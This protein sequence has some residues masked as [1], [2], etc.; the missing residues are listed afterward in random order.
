M[1]T[2][3][4]NINKA[5]NSVKDLL[6]RGGSDDFRRTDPNSPDTYQT[7]YATTNENLSYL[8]NLDVANKDTLVVTGS[9]DHAL[10]LAYF[11]AKS[12]ETFDINQLANIAQ[13]L[14]ITALLHLSRNEFID[15]YSTPILF[16]RKIFYTKIYPYLDELTKVVF[17][18]FLQYSRGYGG[19][20][21]FIEEFKQVNHHLLANN[22]YL[23]SEQAYKETQ[24]RIQNLKEPV[25]STRQSVLE[26]VDHVEP[27]DIIILSNVLR[28]CM[29]QA[30]KSKEYNFE[31]QEQVKKFVKAL[32]SVLNDGGTASLLYIF[33]DWH[34]QN[35]K[36]WDEKALRDYFNINGNIM[37]VQDT[38]YPRQN[39]VFLAKKDDFPQFER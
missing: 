28:F 1:S 12:I 34:S 13:D 25:K 20:S 26:I 31:N 10:N 24:R 8:A 2:N 21:N 5:I 15:F 17:D 36:L 33:G 38:L 4:S 27:K 35:Y 37:H 7:I 32:S 29:D 3:D 22:P 18:T 6:A 11:G 9:G 19:L 30:F 16:D 39:R 14:K 23:S